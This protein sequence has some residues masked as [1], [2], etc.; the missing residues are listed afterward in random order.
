MKTNT[1][2]A[3]TND[4]RDNY[5]KSDIKESF[6][7]ECFKMVVDIL[8]CLQER[9]LKYSIVCNA[10]AISPV[11]MVSKEEECVLKLQ[12]LVDVLFRKRD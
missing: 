1:G 3:A 9:S 5:I 11:N 4:F 7:K 6:M 8:V 10:S 2:T 12:G